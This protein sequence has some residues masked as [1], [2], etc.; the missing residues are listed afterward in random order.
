M[1]R[2]VPGRNSGGGACPICVSC[3]HVNGGREQKGG[4]TYLPA[5]P[6]HA[7]R[8]RGRKG[9]ACPFLC[10]PLFARKRGQSQR[11]G[12]LSCAVP[13]S[14]LFTCEWRQKGG[15]GAYLSRA[16]LHSLA[17]FAVT[18]LEGHERGG[19]ALFLRL[20]FC[21]GFGGT[22]EGAQTGGQRRGRVAHQ[23]A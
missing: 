18:G 19:V 16:T 4:E 5:P 9:G 8:G 23:K 3:S 14:Y 21:G 22:N 20:H 11:G 13:R 12:A 15:K 7:N 1:N 6:L 10:G 2:T 17:P